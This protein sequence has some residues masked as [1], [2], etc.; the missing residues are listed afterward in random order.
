MFKSIYSLYHLLNY[1]FLVRAASLSLWT[2][3]HEVQCW[4]EFSSDIW[5]MTC[6]TL[7]SEGAWSR[8][9]TSSSNNPTAVSPWISEGQLQQ[10]IEQPAWIMLHIGEYFIFRM[11]VQWKYFI[12]YT[13]QESPLTP[14][15]P[16]FQ[17]RSWTSLFK[18]FPNLNTW[19]K[20]F[21]GKNCSCHKNWLNDNNNK[22]N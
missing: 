14:T 10:N 21:S 6:F 22:N 9:R 15:L 11:C 19:Y 12:L 13:P 1:D 18:W 7:K 20:T 5:Y 16:H 3:D 17:D 8:A 2:K 4:A